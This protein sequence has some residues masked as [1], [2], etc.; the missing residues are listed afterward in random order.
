M[1]K[2]E[3]AKIP[4][5]R[6]ELY[7]NLR[8]VRRGA[9]LT[10][11]READQFAEAAHEGQ[12]RKSG[13][14]YY[15][16]CLN[17]A[18]ILMDL[19]GRRVD[20]TILAAA[21]LHDVLEDN[22]KIT[23]AMVQDRF[24]EDV[25]LLVDGVTKISGLP[26]KDRLHQNTEYFRKMLLTMVRDIRVILIKLADRL[27][28]MRTLEHLEDEKR[29]R[30]ARETMDIFA[31]L[32]HRLGIARVKWELEDLS[33]KYLE[34]EAY[35]EI[36]HKVRLKR[37]EREEL[38]RNI[39]NPIQKKLD[40]WDIKAQVQGRPKSFHSIYQKMK[41]DDARFEEIYDLLGLRIVVNTRDEC[42]RV[43][44]LLHD[45]YTPVAGR[46]KDYIAMPKSNMYR[47][48]HTTVIGPHG[49]MVEIQIRTRKMHHTSEFGIAAHYHYKEG[50]KRDTKLAK[51]LGEAIVERTTDWEVDSDDPQLFMDFLR[52]S[53]YPDE[54]FVFTPQGSLIRLQ[55]GSTPVDF[56]YAIH[57]EVGNHC[58]ATKVNSR[59]V[60]LRHKLKS[61]QVVEIITSPHA[62]PREEWTT[63]VASP[64]T[65]AKIRRW[66]KQQYRVDAIN[67]GRDMLLREFKRRK[68]RK[69][70]DKSLDNI[71]VEL[72]IHDRHL[73]F[74][75][76]GEGD[77]SVEKVIT[78]FEPKEEVKTG[79]EGL[80]A[81]PVLKPDRQSVKGVRIQNVDSL[82][83]RLAKCCRPIAGDHVVGIVTRGR[84]VSVH[85]V[86]CPNTFDDRVEPE[87]K[88][89]LSWGVEP[90]QIFQVGLVVHGS[91]RP[92]LLADVAAA[93]AKEGVSIYEARMGHRDKDAR[94]EFVVEIAN[95][96][97][98]ERVM[99]AIRRVKGVSRAERFA[100]SPKEEE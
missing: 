14:H 57:T 75:R 90:G 67:L 41:R 2:E 61:G 1:P 81:P 78:R 32:A 11:V 25:A 21:L 27:H 15:T 22:K 58:A 23:R 83:M 91:E 18:L 93:V 5:L 76:I 34:P 86:D 65:K 20:L 7:G 10:L 53:L 60:S 17:V 56:A 16:H 8:K 71:A 70:R 3:E 98:L 54:I 63:F 33:F 59:Q 99:S 68:I 24:G 92:G 31:P 96:L 51:A 50:G 95:T 85:R 64:R 39:Q 87:R 37:E 29:R 12:P 36:A 46:F 42:Y 77:V 47:S 38:I 82:L 30:I 43:L 28:N 6:R 72:G 69:P 94:G 100:W 19:L 13:A 89:E 97:Q 4:E 45:S 40:D 9:D 66:L 44:G 74:A 73:L 26:F 88:V 62:H 80:E 84:G 55:D 79:S 35:K 48:L 49:R 52:A